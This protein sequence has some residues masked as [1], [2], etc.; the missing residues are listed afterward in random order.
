MVTD[1][2]YGQDDLYYPLVTMKNIFVLKPGK[3]DQLSP[4][5]REIHEQQLQGR[6]NHESDITLRDISIEDYITF[7]ETIVKLSGYAVV[8]DKDLSYELEQRDRYNIERNFRN[9]NDF[10][11]EHYV[12]CSSPK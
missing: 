6:L 11:I 7:I 8:S 9:D 1:L 12:E 5:A 4:Y 10:W 2:F 3:A